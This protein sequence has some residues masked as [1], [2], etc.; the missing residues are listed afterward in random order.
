MKT[1][2]TP[3]RRCEILT[4]MDAARTPGSDHITRTEFPGSADELTALIALGRVIVHRS[5]LRDASGEYPIT[6]VKRVTW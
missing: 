6:L 4:A 2:L 5:D 3:E 1:T